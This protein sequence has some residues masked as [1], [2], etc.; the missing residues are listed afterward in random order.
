MQYLELE[1]IT[2]NMTG[3]NF[4]RNTRKET[5]MFPKSFR[6]VASTLKQALALNHS[7]AECLAAFVMTAIEAKS[8]LLGDVVKRLPGAALGKSKFHRLQ[9]FFREV[10]LDFDAV[11]RMVMGFADRTG[12]KPVVLSLDRTGWQTRGGHEYNILVVSI[13]L[14]DMGLPVLWSDL[15]C[16]GNSALH[17]RQSLVQRFLRLFGR[18]RIKCLIGDREFIGK[19]WFAW[20]QKERIP[21]LMRLRQSDRIANAEGQL[22][23]GENLFRHVRFDEMLDLG[24]RKVFNTTMGICATR[25]RA[26]E[27]L[28]LGYCEGL[29]GQAALAMYRKRWNIETGFEKLKTHGFHLESTRLLGDGKIERVMAALAL[30]AAWSY[31]GGL[32]SARTIAAIKQKKH[33]RAEQ[34]VFARGL[35]LLTT[36]FHGIGTALRRTGQVVFALLYAAARTTS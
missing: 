28:I 18:E 36:L 9:D 31:T 13:C 20:L 26:G 14:G 21:F 29:D 16:L 3:V 5:A 23:K 2:R 11:S 34:S 12:K 1:G 25:T 27:L 19:D 6:K 17:M 15:H 22:T 10:R 35:E 7:R 24:L 32:W 8:I 4:H 33:G 30:A